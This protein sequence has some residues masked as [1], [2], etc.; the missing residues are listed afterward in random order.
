MEPVQSTETTPQ[1]MLGVETVTVQPQSQ[2]EFLEH[3]SGRVIPRRT[4]DLGFQFS[5][6]VI[7]V[8]VEEGQKVETGDVL[9]VL[10]TRQLEGQRGELDAHK[11]RTLAQ[12]AEMKAR[13][14]FAQITVKRRKGLR[15]K[16]II[17]P[18]KYEESVY[19]E[20]A[21]RSQLA[22]ANAAVKEADAAIRR[23]RTT[24]ELS[25]LRAPFAGTIT[26]ID[27]NEGSSLNTGMRVMRIIEDSVPMVRMH[28]PEQSFLS[29]EDGAE[30]TIKIDGRAY[31]SILTALIPQIDT[32][33]RT[34][35]A[36]FI[37]EQPDQFL[38]SGQ[39]AYLTMTKTR[40][41][42][43]FWLPMNALSEG[44][45]GMWRA[46]VLEPTEQAN[47]YRIEARDL[48]LIYTNGERVYVRG[49]ATKGELI[50]SDGVHRVVP[51]QLVTV[52]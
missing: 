6:Q 13:Y 36:R 23:I 28:I 22:A 30:Y 19:E 29:L 21:L 45:R 47:I 27:A 4:S 24:I 44:R 3:Y 33:T 32:T 52:K 10:D 12:L 37:I 42:K 17:S 5:G 41:A 25:K 49:T 40:P 15:T 8:P 11:T 31:L 1:N 48:Q 16:D 39:I 7:T 9:A 18:E 2:F 46:Y 38:Q 20:R 50:I 43:G 26:T 51:K 14:E 34:G 35:T